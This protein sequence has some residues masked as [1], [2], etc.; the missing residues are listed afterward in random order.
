[1]SVSKEL[2][3]E[4]HSGILI[5]ASNIIRAGIIEE[6][7]GRNSKTSWTFTFYQIKGYKGQTMREMGLLPSREVQ[8]TLDANKTLQS[9]QFPF[10]DRYRRIFGLRLRLQDFFD[11]L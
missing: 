1:M 5:E 9:V 10:T 6:T 7:L 8:F 2:T 3:T 11:G 4:V